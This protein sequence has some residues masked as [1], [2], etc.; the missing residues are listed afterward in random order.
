[1]NGQEERDL[2]LRLK[3]NGWV[4]MLALSLASLVYLPSDMT[5]GVIIGGLLVTINLHLLQRAVNRA[6]TPGSRITPKNILPKFYL[7][8]LATAA[9]LFL[10]I[11]Q[12]LVHELGL[13]LGL[14]VFLWNLLI[15]VI[16]LAG[17]IVY[18]TLMK[19]AV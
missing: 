7:C 10:M 8:F 12:H 5:A 16:H 15:L 9:I 2:V 3:V 14:S 19:E 4:I 18:K 11:S 1:V 6:L 13:L 17:K